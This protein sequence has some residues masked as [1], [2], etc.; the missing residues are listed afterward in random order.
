M[1]DA[2]DILMQQ[3]REVEGLFAQFEQARD[4]ATARTICEEI[5]RH[6]TLEEEHVYPVLE[7]D[8]DAKMAEEAE[9]EH[10]EARGLIARIR[11]A[12]GA[13]LTRLVEQLEQAI[14]HHVE[15]E[16]GEVFPKMRERLGAQRMTELGRRLETS[17]A[18]TASAPATSTGEVLDL[19]KEELYEMAKEQGIEGRS[20]MNKNELAR[21][22]QSRR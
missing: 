18:T 21:A 3:H 19:T 6:A 13:E 8:V 22:V 1:P 7:R 15:E 12:E 4:A 9:H 20:K 11:Q 17:T 10:E 2:A 14:E 5:E 16:E